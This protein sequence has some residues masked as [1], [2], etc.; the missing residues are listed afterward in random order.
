MVGALGVGGASGGDEE[1]GHAALTKVLGPQPPIVPPVRPSPVGPAAPPAQGSSRRQTHDSP[2]EQ[3]GSRLQLSCFL[4]VAALVLCAASPPRRT[5]R[6]PSTASSAT[7]LSTCRNRRR[8]GSCRWSFPSTATATTWKTF[9][10]SGCSRRGRTRSSCT[11]RDCR[12]ATAIRGWQVE[13]GEYGDRDL[14]LVDAALASLRKNT[15]STTAASMP[16]GSPTA[17]TSRI[18]C[19]RPVRTCSPHL[20][21]WLDASACGDAEESRGRCCISAARATRRWRLRIRR[22]R[23]EWPC[24]STASRGRGGRAATAAHSTA[25]AR[26]LR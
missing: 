17:L 3:S 23:C 1:C 8:P 22:P 20:R 25:R 26:R 7:R 21:R 19:G 11:S 12:A 18:C 14:K 16:P 5:S 6:G 24:A 2:V 9:S 15:T 10:T 13:P 4:S